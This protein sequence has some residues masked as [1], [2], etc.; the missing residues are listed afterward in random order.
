MEREEAQDQLNDADEIYHSPVD[1]LS[2]H[3]RL[4]D[5]IIMLKTTEIY[6]LDE[7]TYEADKFRWDY[8]GYLTFYIL[9]STIGLKRTRNT[10][11]FEKA[12]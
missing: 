10:C 11:I 6:G 1:I 2:Y 5:G 9:K 3:W 4:L 7:Y 8:A 12:K